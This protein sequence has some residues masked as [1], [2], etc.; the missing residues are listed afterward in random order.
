MEL[1]K[2]L[3]SLCKKRKISIASLAKLSGVRQST[4]HGW[5]TG[6]RVQ[7]LDDLKKVCSVLEVGLHTLL[8]SEVDPFEGQN[9]LLKEIFKGN[10]RVTI[11]KF[12]KL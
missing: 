7:N 3:I 1:S 2:N 9:E 4:L 11:H 8:F 5:T 6:R 10:I 12:E